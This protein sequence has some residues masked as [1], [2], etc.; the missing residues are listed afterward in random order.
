MTPGTA[1]PLHKQLQGAAGFTFAS[2]CSSK[3]SFWVSIRLLPM[4]SSPMYPHT[5]KPVSPRSLSG[6][7]REKHPPAPAQA[8]AWAR[9]LLA[10]W[11]APGSSP[12][13]VRTTEGSASRGK[14]EFGGAKIKKP[15]SLSPLQK[16]RAALCGMGREGGEV[17]GCCQTLTFYLLLF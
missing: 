9:L 15:G 3:L 7:D 13:Q 11:V 4:L 10:R 16:W 1:Q 5:R 2:G 8:Q 12:P 14:E 6:I 17:Q